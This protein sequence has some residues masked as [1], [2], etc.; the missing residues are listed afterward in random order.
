MLG[1]F[2]LLRLDGDPIELKGLRDRALLVF[3]ALQPGPL[4]R[5]KIVSV[6]WEDRPEAQ[7]RQSLRQSLSALRRA[8]IPVIADGNA[9]LAFAPGISCDAVEFDDA[10]AGQFTTSGPAPANNRLPSTRQALGYVGQEDRSNR[11]HAD[12]LATDQAKRTLA[13]RAAGQ[14][15]P[16]APKTRSADLP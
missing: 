14:K 10:A 3:L 15:D 13:G 16:G 5:E 1:R 4:S 6:L 12:T 9:L 8:G 7:A 2:Q 11:D